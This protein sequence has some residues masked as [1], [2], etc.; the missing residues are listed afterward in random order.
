MRA[1]RSAFDFNR[2]TNATRAKNDERTDK[3]LLH[4]RHSGERRNPGKQL[5]TVHRALV[6]GFRRNDARS[7]N[8]FKNM[9]S[10][11][12]RFRQRPAAAKPANGLKDRENDN[13]NSALHTYFFRSRAFI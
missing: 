3:I 1:L 12:N 4:A 5:Q 9:T 7:K 8:F 6:P 11:L 2:K 10:R 13:N